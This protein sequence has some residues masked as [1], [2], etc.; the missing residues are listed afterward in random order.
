[1]D[2]E[3]Q[4]PLHH[5]IKG[6]VDI[7]VDVNEY[8]N[9]VKGLQQLRRLLNGR[10]GAL[11]KMLQT[12]DDEQVQFHDF[13]TLLETNQRTIMKIDRIIFDADSQH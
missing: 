13:H 7:F 10:S 9:I 5:R 8:A 6:G 3:P 11:G 4:V 12:Q 2:M 1:M